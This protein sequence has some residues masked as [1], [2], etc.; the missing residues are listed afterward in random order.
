MVPEIRS[1]RSEIRGNMSEN[2]GLTI[3]VSTMPGH[4]NRDTLLLLIHRVDN[5]VVTDSELILAFPFA[6]KGLRDNELEV[7]R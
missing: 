4:M 3:D 2:T 7:F 6:F 5:P 1:Q